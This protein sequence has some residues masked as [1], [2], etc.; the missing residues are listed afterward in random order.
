[1]PVVK[2]ALVAPPR[3]V[4]TVTIWVDATGTITARG[5]LNDAPE[6]ILDAAVFA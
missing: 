3:I 4:G 6:V 1:M 5:P 2:V